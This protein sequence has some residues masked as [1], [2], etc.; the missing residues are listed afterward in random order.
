MPSC[1]LTY[2]F[3]KQLG[4]FPELDT[5][6][7]YLDDIFYI[8]AELKD[9]FANRTFNAGCLEIMQVLFLTVSYVKIYE[10]W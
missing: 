5:I 1:Y 9:T 10:R 3:P 8:I 6:Q 4:T 2:R 7:S